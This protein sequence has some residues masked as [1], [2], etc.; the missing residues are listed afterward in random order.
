MFA[1]NGFTNMSG[2]KLGHVKT[3]TSI[4][5]ESGN[6]LSKSGVPYSNIR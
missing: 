3:S 5:E 1:V 2:V 6:L 4:Y